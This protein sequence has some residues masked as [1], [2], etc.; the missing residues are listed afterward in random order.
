[1]DAPVSSP[2]SGPT[3]DALN[4]GF[5]G[6]GYADFG[7]TPGQ[8]IQWSVTAPQAGVYNL[9]IRY[10]NGSAANRPL[11]LTVNGSV[12]QAALAFNPTGAWTTWTLA[13]ELVA[14]NAGTN[15]VR[16]TM[17]GTDG[18]NIDHL[19]LSY[20]G[21]IVSPPDAAPSSLTANVVS[22]TQVNLFW[23]DKDECWIADART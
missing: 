14:L 2:L 23:S 21:P 7:N 17:N 19:T 16:L 6:A 13:N 15:T 11:E 4:L 22:S 5:T 12:D 1:M 8:Y 18:P 20:V 3:I 9:G 10:A